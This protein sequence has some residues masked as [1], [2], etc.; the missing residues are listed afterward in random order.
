MGER[1]MISLDKEYP[2]KVIFD[3]DTCSQ[4]SKYGA[5]VEGYWWYDR[6]LAVGIYKETTLE[7]NPVWWSKA[8]HTG[9]SRVPSSEKEKEMQG[10]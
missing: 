2:N 5:M 4:G 1:Q 6:G 3:R 10:P 9:V 8:S 7:L